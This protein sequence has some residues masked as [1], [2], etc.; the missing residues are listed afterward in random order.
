MTALLLRL[1]LYRFSVNMIQ[2]DRQSSASLALKTTS[3]C[4]FIT[5]FRQVAPICCTLTSCM[6]CLCVFVCLAQHFEAPLSL[7][8]RCVGSA[9]SRSAERVKLLFSRLWYATLN[10]LNALLSPEG[11]LLFD[12]APV[13]S[14][15]LLLCACWFHLFQECF[16]ILKQ[17]RV[18]L[19][20]VY[21]SACGEK[22]GFSSL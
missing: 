2:Q 19:H 21:R 7:V 11:S 17:S 5:S 4:F 12:T 13:A 20:T 9:F 3:L 10:F 6:V 16:E 22:V 18:L 8:G 15:H 14:L 1:H